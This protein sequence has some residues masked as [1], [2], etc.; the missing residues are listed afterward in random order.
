MDQKQF[1]LEYYVEL[2]TKR[3]NDQAKELNLIQTIFEDPHGLGASL[4]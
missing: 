3:M 1:I 2:F 4:N